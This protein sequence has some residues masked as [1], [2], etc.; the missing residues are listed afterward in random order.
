[1]SWSI[2]C[3]LREMASVCPVV[4]RCWQLRSSGAPQPW[5]AGTRTNKWLME[6][7]VDCAQRGIVLRLC[8]G[9]GTFRFQLLLVSPR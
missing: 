1:M 2:K 4:L 9:C 3:G 6:S 5:G 8:S 7:N